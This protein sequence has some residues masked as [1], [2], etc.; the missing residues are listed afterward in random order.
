MK[1]EFGFKIES[2]KMGISQLRKQ[3]DE[4]KILLIE[5]KMEYAEIITE[6]EQTQESTQEASSEFK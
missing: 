6:F 2:N 1:K 3:I 5:K 4:Q